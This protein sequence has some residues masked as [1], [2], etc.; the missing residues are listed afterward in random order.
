M[1]F[2]ICVVDAVSATIVVDAEDAER[3]FEYSK[4]SFRLASLH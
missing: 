3:W 2:L 1:G 4:F